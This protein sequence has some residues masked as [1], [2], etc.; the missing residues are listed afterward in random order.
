MRFPEQLK[1]VLFRPNAVTTFHWRFLLSSQTDDVRLHRY[2]FMRQ[3]AGKSLFL[4]LPVATYCFI[5]W[6][7]YGAFVSSMRAWKKYGSWHKQNR[8]IEWSKQI[9]GVLTAVYGF[10]IPARA[11][12]SLK[13]Y[14]LDSRQWLNYAYDFQSMSWHSAFIDFSDQQQ[15]DNLQ[16]LRDKHRFEQYLRDH[17]FP[18]VNT[19]LTLEAEESITEQHLKQLPEHFFFQTQ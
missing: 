2:V 9:F 11:F 16:L 17:G 15:Q 12:Y 6:Y 5:R 7:L 4:G 8:G 14:E 10:A 3:Y 13:L 18:T 1:S 19:V